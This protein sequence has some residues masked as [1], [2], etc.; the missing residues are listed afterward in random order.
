MIIGKPLAGK[1]QDALAMLSE[2]K[3]VKVDLVV[4]N[5]L[6]VLLRDPAGQQFVWQVVGTAGVVLTGNLIGLT[7]GFDTNVF[8]VVTP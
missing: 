2:C 4:P 3:V 7:S 5:V 6:H 8:E 1:W